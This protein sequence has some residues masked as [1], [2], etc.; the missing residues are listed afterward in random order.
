MTIGDSIRQCRKERGLT[1]EDLAQRIQTTPQNVSQ[2]ERGLRNPKFETLQKIAVALGVAWGQ[3]L[4]DTQQAGE[5]LIQQLPDQTIIIDDEGNAIPLSPN[6]AV[7]IG[8]GFSQRS[9]ENDIDAQ[10]DNTFDEEDALNALTIIMRNCG[11]DLKIMSG[12]FQFVGKM[13]EYHLSEEEFLD[14]LNSSGQY[15][16][17]LC[18]KLEAKLRKRRP[19]K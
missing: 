5:Y 1:Q 2:Y 9:P 19:G 16:D 12:E 17:F 14:L 3:L 4:G 13:G 15:V 7:K 11:Y 8:E 10:S 6:R 18:N